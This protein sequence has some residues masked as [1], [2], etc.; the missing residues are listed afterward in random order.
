MA[1]YDA[2][3]AVIIPIGQLPD[4]QNETLI[5]YDNFGRPIA[6]P[7]MNTTSAFW[8]SDIPGAANRAASIG[9]RLDSGRWAMVEIVLIDAVP[10]S[11]FLTQEALA[12]DKFESSNLTSIRL[13]VPLGAEP[14][15]DEPVPSQIPATPPKEPAP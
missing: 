8:A 2:T 6:T 10:S 7:S 15:T 1:G 14:A 5:R 12:Q 9:A 13:V 11:R 4:R 3:G